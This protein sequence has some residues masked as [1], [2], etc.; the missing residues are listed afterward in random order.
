MLAGGGDEES[1]LT[2][3]SVDDMESNEYDETEVVIGSSPFLF[4]ISSFRDA[5]EPAVTAATMVDRV[6]GVGI[7]GFNFGV[8]NDN[9]FFGETIVFRTSLES[10]STAV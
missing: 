9:R 8:G 1:F 6:I 2:I 10:P 5:A 4:L 7:I 3:A